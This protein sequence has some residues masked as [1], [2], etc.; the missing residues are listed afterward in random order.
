MHRN[1]TP[2][3]RAAIERLAIP[4]LQREAEEAAAFEREAEIERQMLAGR[5]PAF[6]MPHETGPLYV[7]EA[8]YD[9]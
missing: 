8:G 2:S 7:K 4:I 1:L 5:G 3:D 6:A 9:G